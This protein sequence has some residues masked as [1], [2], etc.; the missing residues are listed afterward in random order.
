MAD[1]LMTGFPGFLGSAL[2]PRILARR[3]DGTLHCLVQAQHLELARLRVADLAAEHPHVAGRVELVIGDITQ[4]GLGVDPVS[5]ARLA[6]VDEV[7]HLAAVYDLAADAELA[8]RVNVEGTAHVLEFC[9]SRAHLERLQYVSTCYVSGDYV[10]EFPEDELD[11]GQGFLNHYDATK[12]AAE[13]LVRRAMRAGLRATIYRPGIVV[14]DSQTGRT[15]KYDGPYFLASYLRRQPAVAFVPNVGPRDEV[16]VGLVPRDYVIDAIDALSVMERSVGRTY[17]LTDPNPPTARE[18]VEAFAGH[19]GKKVVW[20][21]LPL[22]PTRAAIGAVPGM[23]KLLGIP[24]QTLDYFAFPTTYATANAVSDLEGTGIVC[25][26]FATYADRLL[27]FMADHPEIDSA[28]M[29]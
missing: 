20:V 8:R 16:R 17:A 9:R 14:G 22:R 12:F 18:V 5:R 2:L 4:P 23:E 24:A 10:G 26:P 28:A 13:V 21:P 11:L 27:D 3:P 6:G 29:V 7:W 1:M 19:L 25:P 15:Q